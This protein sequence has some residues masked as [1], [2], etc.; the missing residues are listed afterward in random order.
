M[1]AK[2][3]VRARHEPGVVALAQEAAA[4]AGRGG[5]ARAQRVG[6]VAER[7]DERLRA[8]A[9]AVGGAEPG[10]EGRGVVCGS[11]RVEHDDV[12]AQGMQRVV[13]VREQRLVRCRAAAPVRLRVGFVPD[14]DGAGVRDARKRRA[15]VAAEAPLRAL[16]ERRLA[17]EAEDGERDH[18][19]RRRLLRPGQL[20]AADRS[21]RRLPRPGHP[22]PHSVRAVPPL[23][24]DDPERIRRPLERVVVDS[25][26][27]PARR[28]RDDEQ[29]HGDRRKGDGEEDGAGDCQPSRRSNPC[30]DCL[31]TRQPVARTVRR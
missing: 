1:P 25:D 22:D 29:P 16:R 7:V 23:S 10:Q 9:R 26:E 15:C 13:A 21:R 4:M 5:L 30:S 2:A 18:G 17:A 6:V 12:G 31:S 28:R 27:Q 8:S 14:D 19:V 24:G 11:G 20:V 3:A